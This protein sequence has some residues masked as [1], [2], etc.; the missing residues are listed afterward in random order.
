[1]LNDHPWHWKYQIPN[2]W[3]PLAAQNRPADE[4][5][6]RPDATATNSPGTALQH[7]TGQGSTLPPQ[8]AGVTNEHHW[9]KQ[10]KSWHGNKQKKSWQPSLPLNSRQRMPGYPPGNWPTL[11]ESRPFHPTCALWYPCPWIRKK[12][13]STPRKTHYHS[14]RTEKGV[15]F[16][17]TCRITGVPH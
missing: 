16:P 9:C 2:G 6:G 4:D 12:D 3:S 10:G 8:D 14:H 5:P 15:L 17:R 11:K 7:Y 1:M 13:S